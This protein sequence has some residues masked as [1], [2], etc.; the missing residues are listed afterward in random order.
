VKRPA[1]ARL[2]NLVSD[3]TLTGG[4]LY[5]DYEYRI[6][7]EVVLPWLSQRMSLERLVVADFGCHQGG[8]LQALRDRAGIA[9]GRGFELNP[10]AVAASPFDQ[11]ERFTLEVRDVL[12]LPDDPKYDLVLVRD[13]LEHVPQYDRFLRHVRASLAPDGRAFISFPPYW[14]PFGGH[15]MY[16]ANWPRMT[17]YLH[18]LPSSV[19]WRLLDLRDNEYMNSADTLDDMRSVRATRLTVAGAERAFARAGLRI[20]DVDYFVFRPDFRIRYGLRP[21]RSRL[22]GSIAGLREVALTGVHYLL[23]RDERVNDL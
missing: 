7:T 3:Q 8:V 15:Q 23:T 10:R 4:R 12:A 16:A 13:V 21:R 18:W 2:S 9:E 19:F 11:S 14:S 5:F 1:P 22:V 20:A 6:G 17:P